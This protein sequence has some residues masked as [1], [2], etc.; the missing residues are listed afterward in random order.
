[1]YQLFQCLHV[2]DVLN[3]PAATTACTSYVVPP[4]ASDACYLLK[5]SASFIA[6]QCSDAIKRAQILK[7]KMGLPKSV[8]MPAAQMQQP[9]A[10]QSLQQLPGSTT[11]SQQEESDE[12]GPLER[13][14]SLP[15]QQPA[16]GRGISKAISMPTGSSNLLRAYAAGA[17]HTSSPVEES[18]AASPNSPQRSVL[19]ES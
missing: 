9:A 7:E 13:Q 10:L 14:G 6:Q 17:I 1:M 3:R 4:I 15:S 19:G 12:Q 2:S 18:L 11:S 16:S 8:A 5:V